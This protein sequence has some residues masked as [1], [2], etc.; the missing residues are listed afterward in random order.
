MRHFGGLQAMQNLV[1]YHKNICEVKP[2]QFFLVAVLDTVEHQSYE[3]Q[4]YKHW[5]LVN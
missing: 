2:Q 4:S 3:C 5:L 1:I